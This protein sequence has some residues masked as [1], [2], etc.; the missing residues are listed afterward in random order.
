MIRL[1]RLT[2]AFAALSPEFL[3][4][5]ATSTSWETSGFAEFLKG[6]LTGASLTSDGTLLAGPA[7][8]WNVQLGQPALWS[9]AA[10]PDGS[11]YAATGHSGRVFR[12]DKNGSRSQIWTSDQAEVFAIA[13]NSKGDVFAGTSPNGGIY[14]INNGSAKLIWKSPAK[15]I[16]TITPAK[17]GGL[18]VG[19]GESGRVYRLDATGRGDIYYETEQ[20]NVTAMALGFH[21]EVYAGTEP[22]GITYEITGP[23]TGTVLY[24]SSLPEVRAIVPR[25][26]GSVVIAAM[27]GAISTR[28]GTAVTSTASSSGVVTA[29]N[30]TVITVT[31]AHKSTE[32][33]Q[34]G[35]RPSGTSSTTSSTQQPAAASTGTISETAGLEKSAVYRVLPDRTVDTI[36]SSKEDNVYDV[37]SWGTA[38]LISTD[39]HGRVYRMDGTKSTLLVEPGDGE[40]TR[41]LQTDSRLF[42]ALSNPARVL[43]FD[44]QEH[45]AAQYLSQVHDSGS[46]ARWGHLQ[47][48]CDRSNGLAFQTRTGNSVRPDA[49]WSAWSSSISDPQ[50][51]LISSPIARYM[52]WRVQWDA[53]STTAC[54]SITVPYLP[55]NEAPTIRSV[56]VTSVIGTNP[57]KA[58]ASAS[59]STSAY[60]VTVTDTGEAPAASSSTATSQTVSRLQTTQ[61]QVSWQADDPDSDKLV[62]TLY[63]RPEEAKE[64]QLIRS[65][66][67]ENTLL[68]DPDV[69]ADGRYLF[70][71]V[72][73]DAPSNA[74]QYAKQTEMVSSAVLIDN[75]PPVIVINAK[76]RDESRVD[77]D[78]TASDT[79]SALKRCEYSVDGGYWQPIEANDGIT[80]TPSEKFSIHL[81]RLR[82]GEHLLVIRVFD[83]A[84]NAG[85]ARVLID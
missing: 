77:V 11:L 25:E 67:S 83:A 69:F 52:Q 61:T 49:T 22:N 40:T 62:F 60:S 2:L 29:V 50:Q 65:R 16:W 39:D 48:R 70:R 47:W 58:S 26:D 38:L 44:M 82:P 15:Y 31:E 76:R 8:Q 75:T 6:R 18:F 32:N 74:L 20:A 85:L 28:T 45:G 79:T 34:S 56:S 10:G 42:F 27:G 51:S 23:K 84:G 78:L 81:E 13:V 24:D 59:S 57:A 66:M 63:F 80:D 9:L 33:V 64:W 46:V 12:I 37:I 36:R 17:D 7:E 71:I 43:A 1:L 54:S 19:T 14:Q 5:G 53:G 4:R 55:K 35:A 72:A 68:L 73:S 3:L 30:P 21:G 41:L